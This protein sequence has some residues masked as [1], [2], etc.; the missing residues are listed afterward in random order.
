MAVLWLL[1]FLAS[2]GLYVDGMRRLDLK[3]D[4]RGRQ[5]LIGFAECL[6][7]VVLGILS[8]WQLNRG[9][10]TVPWD[11]LG[12]AMICMS[13]YGYLLYRAGVDLER[14]DGRGCFFKMA[15]GALVLCSGG[16]LVGHFIPKPF[17]LVA[18]I[19]GLVYAGSFGLGIARERKRQ[20][21]V[22]EQGGK[23]CPTSP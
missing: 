1:V 16:A 21:T 3:P 12:I 13:L 22:A 20:E 19:M 6:M 9:W 17:G 2:F 15:F 18:I 7:F 10:P 4:D 14:R 23:L 8:V 11:W 5:F